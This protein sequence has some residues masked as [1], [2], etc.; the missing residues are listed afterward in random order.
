M[1]D[2]LFAFADVL[3]A[4]DALWA[5]EAE[6]D[7]AKERVLRATRPCQAEAWANYRQATANAIAADARYRELLTREA[8]R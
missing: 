3:E 7:E 2:D 6:R 4:R 5:A 8:K 1:A